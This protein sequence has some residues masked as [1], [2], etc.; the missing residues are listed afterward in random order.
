MRVFINGLIVFW[1]AYFAVLGFSRSAPPLTI[2]A[3]A[4]IQGA[5]AFGEVIW[6]QVLAL[7]EFT[8]A[9][10]FVLAL[11][12][13]NLTH[14]GEA[15][16]GLDLVGKACGAAV[17]VLALGLIAGGAADGGLDAVAGAVLAALTVLVCRLEPETEQ[18]S[19]IVDRA[20]DAAMAAAFGSIPAGRSGR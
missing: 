9:A 15:G 16:E 5:T 8:V 3:G 10:L 12:L 7:F 14:R 6:R 17:L 18:A 1:I 19:P 20:Q 2:D 13:G 11:A 4:N